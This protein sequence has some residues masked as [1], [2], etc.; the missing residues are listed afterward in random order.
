MHPSSFNVDRKLV[1]VC[2]GSSH[3]RDIWNGTGKGSITEFTQVVEAPVNV[4][5]GCLDHLPTNSTGSPAS[6]VPAPHPVLQQLAP[7]SQ[8]IPVASPTTT[9]GLIQAP[10]QDPT[11]I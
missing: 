3:F 6:S 7:A 1:L 8:A 9:C 5:E 11:S 2:V 4:S 10:H